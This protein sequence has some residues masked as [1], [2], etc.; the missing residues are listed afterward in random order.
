MGDEA[1][2]GDFHNATERLASDRHAALI[3][4]IAA[5]DVS[6]KN[7]AQRFASS[8]AEDVI[9][10][11]L[12]EV[13]KFA[14]LQRQTEWARAKVAFSIVRPQCKINRALRTVQHRAL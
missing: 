1:G 5:P 12:E 3:C 4:S 9:V 7:P 2:T 14:H 13:E 10:R 6:L 11:D 8:G